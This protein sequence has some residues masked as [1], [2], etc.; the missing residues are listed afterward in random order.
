MLKHE[1]LSFSTVHSNEIR[2]AN[3]L[4]LPQASLSPD[5]SCRKAATKIKRLL[6]AISLGKAGLKLLCLHRAVASS[7][8]GGAKALPI[9]HDVNDI[10]NVL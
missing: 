10:H 5:R 3:V 7:R 1:V 4:A 6:C 8:A 9:F 2:K